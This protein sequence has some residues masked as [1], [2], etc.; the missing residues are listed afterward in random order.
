[1]FIILSCLFL[2]NTFQ[3][4][5]QFFLQFQL[6]NIEEEKLCLYFVKHIDPM[7]LEN[8]VNNGKFKLLI[9]D[10]NEVLNKILEWTLSTKT[11]KEIAEEVNK[12]EKF[13][14]KMPYTICG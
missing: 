10:S 4:L 7:N 9:K 2:F 8:N 14:I 13:I 1:M 12:D 3:E 6:M 11:L 5:L